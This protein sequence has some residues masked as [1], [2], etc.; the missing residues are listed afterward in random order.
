MSLY[1]KLRKA[2]KR[3]GQ[4]QM[5]VATNVGISNAALS[6]YETGYREPDIETL[7]RLALY[8]DVSL[9]ELYGIKDIGKNPLYDLWAVL[10]NNDIAFNGKRYRLKDSQRQALRRHIATFFEQLEPVETVP[11]GDES[12]RVISA[13]GTAKGSHGKNGQ[14]K[15]GKSVAAG[16]LTAQTNKS[17]K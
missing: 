14:S 16:S 3:M 1:D 12:G 8:Y 17:Q 2:R 13:N 4:S 15:E 5:E 7:K 11:R 9:D 6:N 10:R